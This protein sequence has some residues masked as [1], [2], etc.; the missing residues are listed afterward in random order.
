[1]PPRAESIRHQHPSRKRA[2]RRRADTKALAISDAVLREEMTRTVLDSQLEFLGTMMA[3]SPAR[4]LVHQQ[5]AFWK[6]VAGEPLTSVPTERSR[7][8]KRKAAAR[9][10]KSRSNGAGKGGHKRAAK[11]VGR[12][13]QKSKRSSARS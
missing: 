6:G 1:M 4:L 8:A 2:S 7:P 11:V 5:A 13:A 3:W 9:P 10:S 12:S